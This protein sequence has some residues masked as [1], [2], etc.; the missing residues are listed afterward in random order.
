MHPG[1]AGEELQRV[2][3]EDSLALLA[4]NKA[5]FEKSHYRERPEATGW[6]NG[7]YAVD[8][9][10]RLLGDCGRSVVG[11]RHGASS[12]TATSRRGSPFSGHRLHGQHT[13]L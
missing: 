1:A 8:G 5:G 7:G 4:W 9:G 3:V 12:L 10:S 6:M 13:R 2:P 11:G